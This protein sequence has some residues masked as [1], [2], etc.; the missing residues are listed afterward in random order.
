MTCAKVKVRCT[1]I[2]KE[3]RTFQGTNMCMNPQRV[4]PR[5]PGEGY[6]KCKSVCHQIGHAEMVAL[7]NAGDA[8]NGALAIVEKHRGV[9]TDCLS[10]LKDAGV[11][12]IL[13]VDGA[14]IQSTS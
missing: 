11:R 7:E 8:A 14:A 1:I 6:Q 13:T 2:A 5:E 4:C 10:A 12:E 3:G 9:C